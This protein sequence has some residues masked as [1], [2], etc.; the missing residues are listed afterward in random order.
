MRCYDAA[1]LLAH[2]IAADARVFTRR[3]FQRYC[4]AT[5]L[6][7]CAAAPAAATLRYMLSAPPC[8]F[9]PP[10]LFAMPPAAAPPYVMLLCR[11]ATF[12]IA[13]YYTFRAA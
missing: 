5:P 12:S 7:R 1:M 3:H 13:R 9:I 4:H 2:A 6:F 10:S 11:Y 8:R